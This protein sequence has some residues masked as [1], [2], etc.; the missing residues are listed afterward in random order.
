MYDDILPDKNSG[1]KTLLSE[2]LAGPIDSFCNIGSIM[3]EI[4]QILLVEHLVFQEVCQMTRQTDA[5]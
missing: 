5:G 2:I 3:K 1:P 4:S